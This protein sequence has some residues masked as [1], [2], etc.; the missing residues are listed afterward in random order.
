MIRSI[1][2]ETY[3]DN[4]PLFSEYVKAPPDIRLL[5]DNQFRNV[6][7]HARLL[8]KATWYEWRMK[9]LDGLRDGLNRHVDEMKADGDLLSKY[10]A[11]LSS[12]VPDL[13]E[14][15]SSLETEATSMQQLAD[16]MENCDQT[17]LRGAREK[18][19]SVDDE[20]AQKKRQL[21]ELQ[22][23]VQD[24]TDTIETGA[25]LKAEF[26]AQIQRAEQI[27]EECRGWG[28]KEINDLRSAVRTIERQTGWSIISASSSPSG[29]IL[30][31]SY[32]NELRLTFHPGAFAVS[33]SN[34]SG[35]NMPLDLTYSSGTKTAP[36]LPPIASLILKSLQNHLPTIPQQTTPPR[37]LLRFISNTWALVINIEEETRLLG[38]HGMTKLKLSDQDSVLRTRCTLLN[39]TSNPKSKSKVS[40]PTPNKRIDID[41]LVRTRVDSGDL[42][43]AMDIDTDISVSKIYGFGV[44]NQVGVSEDKIRDLLVERVTG[45]SAG[46]SGLGNG[47]WAAAVN[48]VGESVF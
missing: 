37:R 1:E 11:L 7:T 34:T 44:D 2:A 41:F 14:K 19:S 47:V 40:S 18:L 35:K 21:A 5:M 45:K 23:E 6:K 20:I 36:K 12:V 48:G 9:L 16:E 17:E 3:A 26:M 33:S 42:L 38:L 24:K 8:S 13:V 10:E 4:P 27:K 39:S 31:M 32:R 30:Q 29:P 15:H 28:A 22:E 46:S 43:A 25:E